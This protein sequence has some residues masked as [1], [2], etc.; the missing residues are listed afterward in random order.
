MYLREIAKLPR[1]TAEQEHELGVRI[2][3]DKD[4]TAISQLVESN[5]RFVVSYSKRYRGLGVSLI[6][7]IHA[8]NLG[9]IEA[10]KRFDPNRNVSSSPTPSGG[11]VKRW[12]TRCRTK[13]AHSRFPS[14]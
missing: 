14:C 12:F 13:P 6:D 3:R 9:L 5:L 4:E 8:G 2:Q 10:A 11:F 1:L 7:H